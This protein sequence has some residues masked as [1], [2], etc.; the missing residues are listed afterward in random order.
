MINRSL[1]E[2]RRQLGWQGALGIAFLL[3]AGLG[4]MLVIAPLEDRTALMHKRIESA[5]EGGTGSGGASGNSQRDAGSFYASMPN[6]TNVTDVM[7]SIYAAADASRV[8]L[9][10]GSFQLE[11]GDGL[12]VG[13][14]MNFPMV[15][16]YQQ[17]RVLVSRIL[18]D[19]PYVALDQIDFKRDRISDAQL[20]ANVRF[21]LFLR[22]D[23]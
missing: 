9:K 22:Q 23:K 4:H 18:A 11:K 2:A 8:Q 21:T 13:Y 12:S 16:E 19:H 17:I 14:V 20:R 15:G 6:G 7:A 3:T 1:R 10:E 5:R